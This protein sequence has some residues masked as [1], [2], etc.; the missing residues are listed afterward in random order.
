MLSSPNGFERETAQRL[1][2]ERLAANRDDAL[3]DSLTSQAVST[4]PE[5]RAARLGA[6]WV[7]IGADQLDAKVLKGLLSHPDP[8]FRAWAVRAAADQPTKAPELSQLIEHAADDPAPAVRLQATI[9]LGKRLRGQ[10]RP[11]ESGNQ[12]STLLKTITRQAGEP[13]P[14]LLHVCWQ[15]LYPLLDDNRAC[16][17]PGPRRRETDS[18]KSLRR[19]APW[20]RAWSSACW[21]PKTR[22]RSRW[23]SFWSPS[24]RT[25][26][27]LVRRS[28]PS[29]VRSARVV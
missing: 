27:R 21:R 28:M 10:A 8:T 19:S 13:D 26:L 2:T 11:D 20:C 24:V 7:L 5:D 25:R 17:G 14:L 18:P 9:A 12:I 29:C 3:V 22:N 23:D 15:N 16:Q 1:L 4:A 6:A